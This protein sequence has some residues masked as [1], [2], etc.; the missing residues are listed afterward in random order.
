MYYVSREAREELQS[1]TACAPRL[2]QEHEFVLGRPFEGGSTAKECEGPITSFT[3]SRYMLR[4]WLH[5]Y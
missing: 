2:Q 1:E 5:E 3:R 4:G